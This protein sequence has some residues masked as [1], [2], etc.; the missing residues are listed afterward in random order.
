MMYFWRSQESPG[1]VGESCSVIHFDVTESI[2]A[3]KEMGHVKQCFLLHVILGQ[4]VSVKV[5]F[6]GSCKSEKRI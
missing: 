3:I 5:R 4:H 6:Q 2:K 1:K